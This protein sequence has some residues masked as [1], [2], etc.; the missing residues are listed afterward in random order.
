ML[1]SDVFEL[2]TSILEGLWSLLTSMWFI[3]FA[4][5]SSIGI[6]A[7]LAL[8]IFI[9]LGIWKTIAPPNAK[10]PPESSS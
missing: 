6:I 10:T 7:S 3:L 9:I 2:L 1:D 5:N 4:K 8:I